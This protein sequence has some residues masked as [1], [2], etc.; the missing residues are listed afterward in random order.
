MGHK[1]LIGGTAYEIKGGRD[2]IGGTGYSEKKG[3]VLVNGTGY[4][5]LSFY[6]L[7]LLQC[8]YLIMYKNLNSQT[9]LGYG[10]VS[11]TDNIETVITGGTNAKGMCFGEQTDNIQMKFLGIEDFW[12]NKLQWIDGL[13]CDS[14]F[15]ILTATEN[16]NDTGDGYPYTQVTGISN[17]RF[18]YLSKIQGTNN[19][20]F[21]LKEGNGSITT[22]YSDNVGVY[23]DRIPDFGGYWGLGFDSG[24]FCLNI[25]MRA[26]QS[27]TFVGARLMYLHT[28]PDIA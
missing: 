25:S 13:Y 14:A 3:R 7:T 2:L 17:D 20:G 21:C 5:Q 6:P 9:A 12:G 18:G 4:D 15:N 24:A 22:Y 11:V 23:G 27:Y 1:T 10:Y 16:F 28:S 26:S 19:G 8:M